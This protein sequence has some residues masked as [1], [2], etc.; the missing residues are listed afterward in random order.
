M[1]PEMGARI[2]V[3]SRFARAAARPPCACFIA[4]RAAATSSGW[5]PV[6]PC[7]R[8]ARATSRAV[9]L[10]DRPCV[11]AESAVRV[12]VS[13]VRTAVAS[14]RYVAICAFDADGDGI[15]LLRALTMRS[16][17]LRAA[18][19]SV[20]IVAISAARFDDADSESET[21]A[22]RAR[23]GV[24]TSRV[25]SISMVKRESDVRSEEHT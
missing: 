16:R 5:P 12:D 10:D 23:Y 6:T 21:A 8:F 20:C 1:V 25:V 4:A 7:S 13:D 14:V 2:M 24:R 17:K 3:F 15:A 22:S 9:W 19:T 18:R 11:E